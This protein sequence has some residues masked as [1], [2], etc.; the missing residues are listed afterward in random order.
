MRM[1]NLN[2]KRTTEVAIIAGGSGTRVTEIASGLPKCLL[3]LGD[4]TI[5]DKQLDFFKR[6]GFQVIHL[7]LGYKAE[8]VIRH[9]E[10]RKDFSF[11]FH[12]ED[13]PRGSAGELIASLSGLKNDLVVVHGDLFIDF[14]I[15]QMLIKIEDPKIGFV[16]LV[17]PSN[18]M[19]DS[20]VVIVDR[21]NYIGRIQMKPHP[22]DLCVRNLCNAGVFVLSKIWLS[23]IMELG[24]EIGNQKIDL[25]RDLIPRLLQAGVIGKAHQNV[26]RVRDLG[27]PERLKEFE[28][29]ALKDS[30]YRKPIIFLDRDGVINEEKGWIKDL[31]NF[32][33]F[34]DVGESIQLLNQSGYRVV[35]VTNQPVI[36]RGEA[37]FDDI[38]N[39]HAS[40][41]MYLARSGA[42]VDSY[43]VCPHH[44]DAGFEG[45]IPELKM[46][47]SCRKPK[48]GLLSEAMLNF[49]TNLDS[50]WMIGD[51]WRD[52]MAA[53][54]MGIR[55]INVNRCNNNGL[56]P[57]DFID[58]RGAVRHILGSRA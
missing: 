34:Q 44:T 26:G 32:H 14:P 16:Q 38:H 13:E 47:C 18:H 4:S 11:V 46:D 41:D 54:N 58:L 20:D 52:R 42:Y 31:T 10:L 48:T 2:S 17:H 37:T 40:L 27:T 19:N 45:E 3:P 29:S 12:V 43:F 15:D 22:D 28:I 23:R 33:I 49:P 21:E 35:V 39:L 51:T 1:S 30:D 24:Q 5:L 8:S 55:Y 57:T 36:A 53:E 9:L 56:S 7:F 25:D 6:Y 50:C